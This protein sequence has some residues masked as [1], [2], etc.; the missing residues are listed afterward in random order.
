MIP[1]TGDVNTE[2]MIPKVRTLGEDML[3]MS[4]HKEDQVRSSQPLDNLLE[5]MCRIIFFNGDTHNY[6]P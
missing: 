2:V 6:I 1:F 5:G 4:H 3:H